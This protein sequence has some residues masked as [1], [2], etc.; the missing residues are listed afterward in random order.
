MRALRLE[1]LA[2]TPIAYV[3]T[4]ADAQAR[5]EAYWS[6]RALLQSQGCTQA[7]FLAEVGSSVIG[8]VGGFADEGR[9]VVFGVY[10]APAYRGTGLLARFVDAVAAW[11]LQC[12]RSELLL[13][14]ARE[15]PRAL[16]AYTK[17]GFTPTGVTRPHP[18]YPDVTELEL[19]RPADWPTPV[20]TPVRPS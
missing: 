3:E 6:D 5:P 15:N 17:L 2:D 9:T 16:A 19:A 14:V 18:L 10:V 7:R 11:S 12:G 1:M 4:V 20:A 8:A 13:E